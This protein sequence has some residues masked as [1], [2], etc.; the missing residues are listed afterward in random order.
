MIVVYTPAGGEPEHYD[1]RSFLVSEASIAARTIDTKW[2]LIKAGLADEDLDAMRVVAWV[3]KKRHDPTLRFGDFDPGV[4]ELV[5]RYDKDEVENW[6][7]GAFT[8]NSADPT[9][10]PDQIVAALSEVPEAA[11]D[12]EHARAFIEKQRAAALEGKD[13]EAAA[14]GQSAPAP[15]SSAKK[16][17]TTSAPS[18]S[19]SS[20]TS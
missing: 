5:T 19:G 16:T 18:T 10:T 11:A 8:L 14:P 6:V 7:E 3:L 15:K 2:P 1:A 17:S 4:E 20:V 9:I 13:L 12:P